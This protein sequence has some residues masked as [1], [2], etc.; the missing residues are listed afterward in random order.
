MTDEDQVNA[1]VADIEKELGVIGILVNNEGIILLL[2]TASTTSCATAL[3][4]DTS[5][6]LRQLPFVSARL[7]EADIRSISSSYPRHRLQDG[8]IRKT[9]RDRLY[10]LLRM[11]LISL[12]D[13]SCMWMAESLHTSANS[14]NRTYVN[15]SENTRLRQTVC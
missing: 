13:T 14:R 2:N 12:T 3:D 15:S 9:C 6:H 5:L 1:M 11:L 10:S 8:A 7:T 4:Q